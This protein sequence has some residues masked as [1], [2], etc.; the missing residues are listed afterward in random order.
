MPARKPKSKIIEGRFISTAPA[1]S[2]DN[3]HPHAGGILVDNDRVDIDLV[4][5]LEGNLEA[6]VLHAQQ[7]IEEGDTKLGALLLAKRRAVRDAIAFLKD[8]SISC[9]VC[10]GKDDE[11]KKACAFCKGEAMLKPRIV[12]VFE[13]A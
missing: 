4:D 2:I 8:L 10:R 7:V 5:E 6:F 13:R 1:P 3:P 12:A 9:P 11:E